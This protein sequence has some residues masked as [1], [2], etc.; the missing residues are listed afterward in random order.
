MVLQFLSF[1]YFSSVANELYRLQNGRPAHTGVCQKLTY[2]RYCLPDVFIEVFL[3][4]PTLCFLEL[5]PAVA[6]FATRY[7]IL[8]NIV[9]TVGFN[10]ISVI[11]GGG[12]NI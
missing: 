11:I 9:S 2:V 10:L 1:S 7:E 6:E 3:L 5:P 4:P 12:H 8:A